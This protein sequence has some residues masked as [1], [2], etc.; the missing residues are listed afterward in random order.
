MIRCQREKSGLSWDQ[1]CRKLWP[2]TCR[3]RKHTGDVFLS[4]DMARC[5][6]CAG[7]GEFAGRRCDLCDGR[8]LRFLIP[9]DEGDRPSIALI[10]R[11]D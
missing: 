11:H 9:K 6:F 3:A 2:I 4:T 1:R 10:V 5:G 7:L 8:G